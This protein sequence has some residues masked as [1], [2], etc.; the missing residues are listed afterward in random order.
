M[1]KLF[2]MII[3]DK[4]FTFWAI[5]VQMYLIIIFLAKYLED[6]EILP[7]FAPRL[8]FRITNYI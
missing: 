1:A 2:T 6:V 8:F 3:S 7:I 5:Q 4:I